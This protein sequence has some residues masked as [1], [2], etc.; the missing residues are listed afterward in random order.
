MTARMRWN[1]SLL[2]RHLI[3]VFFS[4]RQL[5]PPTMFDS[6]Y[7]PDYIMRTVPHTPWQLPPICLPKAREDTVTTLLQEQPDTGKYEG[8]SSAYRSMVFPV[9]K[10]QG[11]LRLVHDLQPLNRVTICDAGVPPCV[12]DMIETF[13]GRSVYF[14]ADLKAGYDAMLPDSRS[15]DLTA[16]HGYNFGLLR[17]MTLPQGY[18]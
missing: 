9:K 6:K 16:F 2:F 4:Y 18:S 15:R 14:I 17:L 13:A 11:L 10:K 1:G 5:S 8:S 3:S 7:Y 12:D